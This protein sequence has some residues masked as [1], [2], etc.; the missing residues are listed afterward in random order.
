[1]SVLQCSSIYSGS[2]LWPSFRG[3]LAE[4]LVRWRCGP[5]S[6]L[7][8][9]GEIAPRCLLAARVVEMIW[10]LIAKNQLIPLGREDQLSRR[11]RQPHRPAGSTLTRALACAVYVSALKVKQMPWFCTLAVFLMFGEGTVVTAAGRLMSWFSFL[12]WRSAAAP[13][14]R[15]NEPEQQAP[16]NHH[17]PSFRVLH[18]RPRAGVCLTHPQDVPGNFMR[19][20]LAPKSPCSPPNLGAL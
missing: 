7:R 10:S 9:C 19:N 20:V 2:P 18:R 3:S 1:M 17:P 14:N 12:D 15:L 5:G 16:R 6:G 8:I 4:R 13:P 11:H